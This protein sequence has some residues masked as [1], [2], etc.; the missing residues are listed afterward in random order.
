MSSPLILDYTGFS[1]Q[2]TFSEAL[3]ARTCRKGGVASCPSQI[4]RDHLTQWLSD[5]APASRSDQPEPI[6]HAALFLAGVVGSIDPLPK[7][8][9]R[10]VRALCQEE[11]TDLLIG[12]YCGCL[13]TE[14]FIWFW[15]T[16]AS[17]T[18]IFYRRDGARL[19]WSTDPRMLVTKQ[20]LSRDGLARC[21]LG[22]DVFVYPGLAYVAAGTIVRCSVESCQTILFDQLPPTP[23]KLRMTLPELASAA[24]SALIE[25]TRPLAQARARVGL[26]LS[27]GIDSAAV[28]AALASQGAN[29]TAY[30]LQFE[31]P[32]ADESAYA[33]A[34]CQALSLPLVIIPARTEADYLSDQ[35]RFP[36][37]YGHAGYRWMQLLAE[38]ASRDGITLL[39]TGRG[40]DPAFGPLDSY[41]LS[42]ICSAPIAVSEK[43][44]MVVGALSTDWLL[45]D[46]VRSVKRSHSLINSRS[47]SPGLQTRD[48][49]PPFLCHQDA[50]ARLQ[51]PY[52]H[53]GFSPHDLVLETTVWQPHGLHMIHPYH[54]RAVQ[55]V[56]LRIPAAYRLI[57]Y[58]GMRVVKPVLRLAFS[59]LLPLQILRQKRGGWLS[60]PSQEYCVNH[61]EILLG[62]LADARTQ[63]RLLGILDAEALRQVLENHQLTRMYAKEL[64]ATAMTELFVRQTDGESSVD[65]SRRGA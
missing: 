56:A 42:D 13:V 3:P 49:T 36:H 32:A 33:Q 10:L 26:L 44:Q 57:P 51:A 37:P 16:R 39:A 25:A 22:E 60:V 11:Y 34:V 8:S 54:H 23:P 63:L 2:R 62:L 30:H 41:G 18:N 47:L 58:R 1:G 6:R 50:E 45:P 28:A 65:S 17:T 38:A 43:V 9:E 19:C 20:D 4:R 40:G 46:L 59:D 35:W 53:T 7:V 27:G 15:K 24:R 48:L 5:V 12:D 21:C 61:R 64:I 14:S 52:E 31:H 55:H 29:I